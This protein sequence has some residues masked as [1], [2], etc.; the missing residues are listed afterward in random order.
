MESYLQ[1]GMKILDVGAGG[2]EMLYLLGKKGCEASGIEPNNG[3]AN[4]ATEQYGVD[5]QVGFA[6]DADFNPN[7]FDA[8]LLFHVLEHMEE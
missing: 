7:T 4:Y 2:G 3:Y 5:I 8:I 1:K 6:E